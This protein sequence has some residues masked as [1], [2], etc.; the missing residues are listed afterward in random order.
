MKKNFLIKSILAVALTVLF[1][2]SALAVSG[3]YSVHA[4]VVS[5]TGAVQAVLQSGEFT[6]PDGSTAVIT[7]SQH[8]NPATG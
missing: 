3:P 4:R 6:V 1:T 2:A 5:G 8:D 7:K